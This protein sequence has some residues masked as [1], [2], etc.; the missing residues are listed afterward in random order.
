MEYAHQGKP[1]IGK[2]QKTLNKVWKLYP[3][4]T[5]IN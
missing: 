5:D 4:Y 2:L 1:F 3:R